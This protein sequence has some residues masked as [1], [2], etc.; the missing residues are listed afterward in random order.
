V[1]QLTDFGFSRVSA[2]GSGGGS[3]MDGGALAGRGTVRWM[4]PELL[5]APAP[6]APPAR[7]SFRTDVYAWAVLA[8]QLL[9]LAPAPYPGLTEQQAMSAAKDQFAAIPAESLQDFT[10]FAPPAVV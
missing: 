4:A 10:Q 2:A 8:W 1:A 5:R 3:V 6:D 9:A 7:P